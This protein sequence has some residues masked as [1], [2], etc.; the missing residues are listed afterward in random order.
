MIMITSP[1]PAEG[2][3]TVVQNLGIALAETGRRV[4]LVD[5]DFRRPHLHREFSLSNEWGLID[6]LLEDMPLSE[7]PPE[8]LGSFTGLPGLSILANRVTENNVSKALYSPRLRTILES[9]TKRYDMVLVDAPPLLSVADARI[10]APLTDALI[11]VLRSGV[12]NRESALEAYQR[13]QE[14]G[15]TLLG[16]VLTD[17]N[18]SGARK[19]QYDYD[20]G[21]PSRP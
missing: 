15:L 18:L 2:K 1:G 17:Y 10:I 11:L 5:A 12:T 3:T 6:L 7:Y 14:D 19:Q 13:I 4:L 16:T 21:N 9:L 20:Y 8:R